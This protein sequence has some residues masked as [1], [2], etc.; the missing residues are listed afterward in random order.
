MSFTFVTI[1]SVVIKQISESFLAECLL[2]YVG[3]IGLEL[4][5]EKTRL[6]EF[7]RFAAPNLEQR[8]E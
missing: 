7:G 6:I 3:T 2:G 5:G 8:G 4:N 1:E